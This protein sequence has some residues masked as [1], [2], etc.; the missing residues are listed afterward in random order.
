MSTKP[1]PHSSST[2]VTTGYAPSAP[3]AKFHLP[4]ASDPASETLV[5][6]ANMMMQ[7]EKAQRAA[8]TARMEA[9]AKTQEAVTS[10]LEEV[11]KLTVIVTQL[12]VQVAEFTEKRKAQTKVQDAI[13]A[14]VQQKMAEMAADIEDL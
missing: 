10:A 4:N 8:T 12:G 11:K 9:A 3:S 14:G 2:W 5:R 1:I 7:T 6:T 13:N